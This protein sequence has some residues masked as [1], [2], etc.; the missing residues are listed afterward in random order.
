MKKILL[1]IVIIGLI[2]VLFMKCKLVFVNLIIKVN[3][4]NLKIGMIYYEV[5]RILG[6]EGKIY[7]EY[8]SLNFENFGVVYC[9]INNDGIGIVVVFNFENKL[10]K[11]IV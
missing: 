5:K 2:Y 9:W 8:N 3:Y 10:I 1:I 4:D 6:R 7:I 11:F